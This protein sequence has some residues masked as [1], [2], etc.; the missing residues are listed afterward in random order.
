MKTRQEMV[1]D[2][3]LALAG[4]PEYAYPNEQYDEDAITIH[5]VACELADAYLRSLG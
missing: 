1:Y 3:M 5:T 2:F 4:N